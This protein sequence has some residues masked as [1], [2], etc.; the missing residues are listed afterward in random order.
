MIL[1]GFFPCVYVQFVTEYP[2]AGK[3]CIISICVVALFQNEKPKQVGILSTYF[4][5]DL[6][7]RSGTPTENYFK[8]WIAFMIGGTVA[9][10]AELVFS[11]SKLAHG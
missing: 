10:S 2:R 5:E 1:V 6:T 8:R 11:Q 9:L 4:D 3:V 7:H